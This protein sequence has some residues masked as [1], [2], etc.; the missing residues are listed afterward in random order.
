MSKGGHNVMDFKRY[1]NAYVFETALPGTK[2]EVSFKPIS[3]GQIKRLL[4]YETSNDADSIEKALDQII[5]ECVVSEDFNIDELYLQ[6]RFYLLVDLR[7]AT[8]GNTYNF[9]SKCGKCESQTQQ[10]IKLSDLP[11]KTLDA[12]KETV[13]KAKKAKATTMKRGAKLIDGEDTP[14][15]EAPVTPVDSW[16]VIKL[17]ENLSIKVRHNTRG[18]QKEIRMRLE[19]ND[20]L[21]PFQK[22]VEENTLMYAVSIQEVITPEGV[23]DKLTFEDKVYLIENIPQNEIE[24]I[25]K[26]FEDNDFGIDFSFDVKCIHCGNEEKKAIPLESFFFS[27]M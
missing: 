4:L 11:V 14:V 2:Q 3:T 23:D 19:T 25:T 12:P 16:G 9:Q 15:Q 7:K 13:V 8:K 20:K 18:D 17:N 10:S 21:T 24:V 27:A 26:W 22:S 6:D 1:V 5:S